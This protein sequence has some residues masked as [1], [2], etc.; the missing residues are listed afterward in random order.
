MK[1]PVC[2]NVNTS[3]LCENCGFDSSRDYEQYPTFGRVGEVPSKSSLR[4]KRDK[5]KK[6]P[7]RELSPEAYDVEK[8][9]PPNRGKEKMPSD[10]KLSPDDY[11]VRK[12]KKTYWDEEIVLQDWESGPKMPEYVYSS[13]NKRNLLPLLFCVFV[14]L[15]MLLVGILV[16]GAMERAKHVR[17]WENNVL[18]TFELSDLDGD[19]ELTGAEASVSSVFGSDVLNRDQIRSITV[20]DSLDGAPE[21]AWDVSETG[22][23][24]VLAWVKPDGELYELYLA[25]D[26][27]ISAPKDSKFLFAGYTNAVSMSLCNAFHTEASEDLYGMFYECGSL[28]SLDLGTFDTSAAQ[29]MGGMFY[30][31]SSLGDLILPNDFVPEHADTTDMYYQCPGGMDPW[32]ENILR[33]DALPDH[34]IGTISHYAV[35]GSNYRRDQI[36][37]VT[38]LDSLADMPADAWD[39]SEAGD[40][41]V[42]A[43]VVPNGD[44]Y[45]LFIGAEGGVC[46]GSSCEELFYGYV[47][48]T[49]INLGDRFDTSNV[50]DMSSMF[51]LCQSLTEL[52][53]G[54]R[55]DTS[56]V[57][58]M[59]RMFYDCESLTELTLGDRF[60]TSNVQDMNY[61]FSFCESLTDLN[62]G[63]R[64]VTTNASTSS[65]FH[66]CPA[67]EN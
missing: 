31:C 30:S 50:Q 9:M 14:A 48:A 66:N 23:G 16:G 27:G 25:G 40:G 64:F 38:I 42:M 61:M 63:D 4:R 6:P 43:W 21:G 26:G 37:S 51:H 55:F 12:R 57:Q 54:D 56:N 3:M 28:T 35:F 19:G 47:Y 52:T 58:D 59:R 7:V 33:I 2:D 39:V 53:L 34:Y 62:L 15:S 41:R 11:D 10:R 17:P 49:T 13:R 20:L 32:E 5:E 1:C 29:D 65:M 8:R 45:D 36:R 24:A 46:A 22:D 44:L 60:D 67:G 18:R